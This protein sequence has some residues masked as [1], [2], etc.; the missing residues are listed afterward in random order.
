[1]PDENT[2]PAFEMGWSQGTRE[3]IFIKRGWKPKYPIDSKDKKQM[4]ACVLLA[5]SVPVRYTVCAR[6][7]WIQDFGQDY[8]NWDKNKMFQC[9][10]SRNLSDEPDF[11][12]Q[13]RKK[14]L[15]P[16]PAI[17]TGQVKH[18]FGKFVKNWFE[19]VLRIQMRV[20]ILEF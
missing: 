10:L 6:I 19:I 11:T 9:Y 14:Y 2:I 18:I 20:E 13:H 4:Y 15:Q 5:E 17:Y 16:Y 8:V 7:D 12:H 3:T 1:M